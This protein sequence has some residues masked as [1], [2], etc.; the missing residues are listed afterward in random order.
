MSRILG[1]TGFQVNEIGLGTWAYSGNSYGPV[2][3]LTAKNVIRSAIESGVNFI[4][5]ADSY[6]NGRSESLVGESI[7]QDSVFIA[8][9]AG[10]DFYHG[11]VKA[12]FDPKYLEFALHESLKRLHL[13]TLDLFQLHN[14]PVQ[15]CRNEV[16]LEKLQEFQE[17]GKIRFW[18]VSIHLPQEGLEWIKHTPI[19]S[20]QVVLNMMN[21]SAEE[22]LFRIAK[23]NNI[24]IIV[25]EPLNCGLLSGKY[26]AT[27]QFKGKDHRRRWN[28]E[29]L[30]RDWNQIQLIQELL[31]DCSVPL[32]QLAIEFCL[33]FPEVSVVIPGAKS[34]EQ[35][36]YNLS[37]LIQK[38][39]DPTT[40]EKILKLNHTHP[41]FKEAC[42][43]N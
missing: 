25:R 21:V 23:E 32:A 38:N 35:L 3:E 28:G 33:S 18:G 13:E 29:K 20:I 36:K 27:H 42:F 12:N 34:L 40:V 7:N 37:A 26:N 6:G 2:E 30:K 8:S 15:L 4:D 31:Q 24:G 41:C 9:K 10:W 11:P 39:L 14:P 1:K 16:L 19:Q 17:K 5:T 22:K 43:R